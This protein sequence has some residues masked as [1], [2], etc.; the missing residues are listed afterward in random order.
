MVQQVKDL[1][2]VQVATVMQFPSLAQELPYAVVAAQN[3]NKTKQHQKKV[4]WAFKFPLQLV[5][6]PK[7]P[8][9]I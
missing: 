1:A 5:N 8:L 6:K 3:K 9:A 4:K 2:L 7:N